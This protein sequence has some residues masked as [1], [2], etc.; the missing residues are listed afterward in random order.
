MTSATDDISRPSEDPATLSPPPRDGLLDGNLE[1]LRAL[2]PELADA[3]QVGPRLPG[4]QLH[5]SRDGGWT[6]R[7]PDESGASSWMGASSM[8][9]VSAEAQFGSRSD[10][11]SSAVLPGMLTGIEPLVVARTLAASCAVFVCEADLARVRLALELYDYRELLRSRRLVFL[12]DPHARDDFLRFFRGHAGFEFPRRLLR[13]PQV[14]AERFDALQRE[15]EEAAAQVHRLQNERVESLRAALTAVPKARARPPAVV[16]ISA[17]AD[18]ARC[19]WMAHVERAMRRIGWSGTVLAP[20]DP[21]SRHRVAILSA[22]QQHDADAVLLLDGAAQAL[23]PL[24]MPDRQV[25]A[26][27]SPAVSPGSAAA[28]CHGMEHSTFVSTR[29]QLA[30]VHAAHPHA[31][32]VE[33]LEPPIDD[34]AIEGGGKPRPAEGP[35]VQFLVH[36]ADDRPEAVGIRLASHESLVAAMQRI[37]LER[38]Q[39]GS[40][41]PAQGILAEAERRAGFALQ[42]DELRARLEELVSS[43]LVPA[44]W[45]RAVWAS[46]TRAGVCPVASGDLA[47]P[48]SLEGAGVEVSTDRHSRG[49]AEAAGRAVAVWPVCGAADAV[50]L[51]ETLATGSAVVARRYAEDLAATHPM[52]HKLLG[53]VHWFDR[54]EEAAR[55]ARKLVSAPDATPQ[56][57]MWEPSEVERHSMAAR[58]THLMARVRA[59]R[60]S[61]AAPCR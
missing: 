23:A 16:A 40:T 36:A 15:V 50:A 53:A 54:P 37:C 10:S 20:S 47:F 12:T 28:L 45:T 13:T 39:S 51:I 6:F 21:S 26:W 61:A 19:A 55:I 18:P 2:Q 25:V 4:V 27:L 41:V 7:I 31:R 52:L 9:R 22:V 42:D 8:P 49:G 38:V 32:C 59:M 34:E 5:R 56:R 57:P 30:A 43:R 33:L 1:A 24:L 46:L 29:A 44:A 60:D 14:G 48:L 35:G 58:L 11:G 17:E 3:L